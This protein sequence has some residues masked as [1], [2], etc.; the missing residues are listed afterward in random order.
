MLA[1]RLAGVPVQHLA[2][3][4]EVDRTSI[5]HWCVKFQIQPRADFP[6]FFVEK[7]I[8]VLAPLPPEKSPHKYAS[9]LEDRKIN[10]GKSYKEYLADERKR[11]PTIKINHFAAHPN[12]LY[13]TI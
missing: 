13:E 6:L 3:Y 1:K 12:H 11:N 2:V 8:P 7:Q 4:Y 10:P 5:R 9:L